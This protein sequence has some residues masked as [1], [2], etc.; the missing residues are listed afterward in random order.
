MRNEYLKV[1][2]HF[3]ATRIDSAGAAVR[4]L[5]DSK[6]RVRDGHRFAR[7]QRIRGLDQVNR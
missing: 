3:G 4:V 2:E 7:Y 6:P 5:P 1:F